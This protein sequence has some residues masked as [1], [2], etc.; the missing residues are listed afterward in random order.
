[1]PQHLVDPLPQPIEE[2]IVQAD[3]TAVAPGP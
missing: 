2:I 3:L 1:M